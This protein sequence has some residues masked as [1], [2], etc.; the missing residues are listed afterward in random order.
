MALVLRRRFGSSKG[1]ITECA[2]SRRQARPLI[3]RTSCG[4]AEK[5][6]DEIH[7]G[8]ENGIAARHCSFA[9]T[10]QNRFQ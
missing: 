2:A 10:G 6:D 4:H 9:S 8:A 1:S 3:G 7:F 5:G